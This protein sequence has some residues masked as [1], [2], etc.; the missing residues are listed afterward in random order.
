MVPCAPLRVVN[1]R[2][3][4]LFTLLYRARPLLPPSPLATQGLSHGLKPENCK[5][6]SL[7]STESILSLPPSITPGLTPHS[8][9]LP[10]TL[11]QGSGLEKLL[12]LDLP[13]P[14]LGLRTLLA[15]LLTGIAGPPSPSLRPVPLLLAKQF[16]NTR[17]TSPAGSPTGDP[18]LR[19]PP[20]MT[21]RADAVCPPGPSEAIGKTLVAT[22]RPVRTVALEPWP[23]GATVLLR[24]E[25]K[26][27]PRSASPFA[28]RLP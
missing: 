26:S 9:P 27:P 13:A 11:C 28:T 25:L 20:S 3:L 7:S 8:E 22:V 10:T 23:S 16:A 2:D 24:A 18:V 1:P 17:L 12:I 14:L 21:G 19:G 5:M 15:L 4:L 6:S